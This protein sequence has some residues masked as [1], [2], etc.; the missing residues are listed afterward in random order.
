MDRDWEGAQRKCDGKKV[1]KEVLNVPFPAG[2]A[3][4]MR[5]PPSCILLFG[6]WIWEGEKRLFI[7][8]TLIPLIPV[9]CGWD[10]LQL[11]DDVSGSQFCLCRNINV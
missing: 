2:V 11:N 3:Q 1:M 8:N 7:S 10:F 5:N 9:G 4:L 6:V